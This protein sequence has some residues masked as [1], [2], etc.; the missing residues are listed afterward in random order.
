MSVVGRFHI[1]DV[2]PNEEDESSKVKVKVRMNIHGIFR[3]K[4]ATMVEK[5]MR[6]EA[7]ETEPSVEQQTG[8]AVDD[9]KKGEGDTAAEQPD[10]QQQ[11]PDQ[12]QKPDQQQ[13]TDQQQPEGGDQQPDS[14]P[15]PQQGG[16]K[17]NGEN[18]VEQQ[19]ENM[20]VCTN[21]VCDYL[22]ACTLCFVTIK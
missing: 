9:T 4:S 12:Q 21:S 5:K 20:D 16:E 17:E 11:Q 6:A 19:A 7:M 8:A 10:Q 13:Q 15:A 14:T 2:K 18:E 1:S 22:S 3:I